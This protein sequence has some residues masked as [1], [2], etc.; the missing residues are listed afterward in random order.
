MPMAND[1]DRQGNPIKMTREP[2]GPAKATGPG[3]MGDQALQD[4]MIIL[5]ACWL[6][7]IMLM[8]SLRRYN[9]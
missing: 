8:F 1:G 3:S 2:R 9:V 6:I 4:A 5:V 7:L